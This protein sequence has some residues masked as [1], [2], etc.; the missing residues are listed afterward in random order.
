M[1]CGK[2]NYGSGHLTWW[3]VVMQGNPS[4]LSNPSCSRQNRK[5]PCKKEPDQPIVWQDI[6]FI[7]V[8]TPLNAFGPSKSHIVYVHPCQCPERVWRSQVEQ[9]CSN[10]GT[11][12]TKLWRLD[13]PSGKNFCNACGIYVKTHGGN[14]RPE[15]LWL[16]RQQHGQRQGNQVTSRTRN[17]EHAAHHLEVCF[18]LL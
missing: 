10:C 8:C 9:I 7:C 2:D 17:K 11:T 6:L 18:C 14:L 4:R 16:K 15:R 3:S 12:E 5:R 13:K 1:R